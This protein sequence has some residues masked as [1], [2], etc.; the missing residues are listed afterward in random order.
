MIFKE[1]SA[2][3][4]RAAAGLRSNSRRGSRPGGP[5]A[6]LKLLL[7]PGVFLLLISPLIEASNGID[8]EEGRR[9]TALFEAMRSGTHSTIYSYD[10]ENRLT[11][12]VKNN[13]DAGGA[14]GVHQHVYDYRT[15]R[16]NRGENGPSQSAS[17][18][19]TRN[20][21]GCRRFTL[22]MALRGG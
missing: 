2:K 21:I 6:L 20:A 9:V 15:R 12:L 13:T 4:H 19:E 3:N 7:I 11:G 10:V 8:R 14:A 17:F 1:H 22:G 16:G 18:H 5:A